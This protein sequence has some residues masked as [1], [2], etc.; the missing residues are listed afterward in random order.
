MRIATLP[1][2]Y[3]I[4]HVEEMLMYPLVVRSLADCCRRAAARAR[5]LIGK[6]ATLGAIILLTAAAPLK[7]QQGTISGVVTDRNQNPLA[8]AQVMVSGTTLGALTDASGRFRISGVPG[9]SA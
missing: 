6:R 1:C 4:T 9:S 5:T 7:A 3:S 8:S 2:R